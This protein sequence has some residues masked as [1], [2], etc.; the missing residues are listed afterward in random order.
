MKKFIIAMAIAAATATPSLAQYYPVGPGPFASEPYMAA[1]PGFGAGFYG[2]GAYEPGFEAYAA[3][4]GPY[5]VQP[6][7]LYAGG[8][9]LGW[10]P[11][12]NVRLEL[13]RNAGSINA[14]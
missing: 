8:E 1:A 6:P 11:D 4:P 2:I 12:P 5:A 9:Y 10:D 3:A 14:D 13:L 7:G